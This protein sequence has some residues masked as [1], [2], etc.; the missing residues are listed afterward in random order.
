VIAKEEQ[1]TANKGLLVQNFFYN[2][3]MSAKVDWAVE[4]AKEGLARGQAVIFGLQSTG[5]AA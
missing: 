2:L 5:E 3:C 1:R 4:L